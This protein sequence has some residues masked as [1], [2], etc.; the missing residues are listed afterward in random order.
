MVYCASTQIAT[1]GG[2][3][4]YTDFDGQY[5]KYEHVLVLKFLI[6]SILTMYIEPLLQSKKPLE[7]N[8][9]QMHDRN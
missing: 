2:N 4:G 1:I 6:L 7:S 9:V 8:T 3:I 5:S